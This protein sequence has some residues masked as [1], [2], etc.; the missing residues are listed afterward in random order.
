ESLGLSLLYHE[1]AYIFPPTQVEIFS[2]EDGRW[3][4]II[5][6]QPK[7]SEKIGEIRSELLQYKIQGNSPQ[8]IK[9]KLNPIS[10]L[11]AW[12]PGAGAKG[13]VFIDEILLN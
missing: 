9:V 3:K 6:D 4:S 5:R 11:P 13:W 12:H 8:K 1:S 7:Q 2:W 10:S